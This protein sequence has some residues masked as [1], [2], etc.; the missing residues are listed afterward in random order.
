MSISPRS[1]ETPAGSIQLPTVDV[2]S[3]SG[4]PPTLPADTFG[5]RW[6]T[7][8]CGWHTP[9]KYDKFYAVD[10]RRTWATRCPKA[11]SEMVC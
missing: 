2:R 10:N 3:R 9:C 4:L 1:Q 6:K 5:T 7:F 8:S 11:V